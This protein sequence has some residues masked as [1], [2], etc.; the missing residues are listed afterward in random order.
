MCLRSLGVLHPQ[1]YTGN[2]TSRYEDVVCSIFGRL[3]GEEEKKI[4]LEQDQ[5]AEWL[6]I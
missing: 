3:P 1:G 6:C 2:N 5:L 4:R